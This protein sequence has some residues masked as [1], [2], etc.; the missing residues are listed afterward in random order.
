MERDGT[1]RRIKTLD[2]WAKLDRRT[3]L[4]RNLRDAGVVLGHDFKGTDELIEAL[5][6][7]VGVNP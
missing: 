4:R 6:K 2:E 7:V 3:A 5:A 1:M